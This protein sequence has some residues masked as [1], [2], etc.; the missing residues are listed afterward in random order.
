V[1]V[2]FSFE[3][4]DNGW[5]TF[6]DNTDVSNMLTRQGIHAYVR[7]FDPR[8]PPLSEYIEEDTRPYQNDDL[9]SF[10]LKKFI[11][12]T[13]LSNESPGRTGGDNGHKIILPPIIYG[14]APINTADPSEPK[15]P[16]SL[17]SSPGKQSASDES[18]SFPTDSEEDVIGYQHRLDR[19]AQAVHNHDPIMVIFVGE[20]Q[21]YQDRLA[22][23][24]FRLDYS[25]LAPATMK[26]FFEFNWKRL[27]DISI[28]YGGDS[29]PGSLTWTRNQITDDNMITSSYRFAQGLKV[30]YQSKDL[31]GVPMSDYEATYATDLSFGL[32]VAF[33]AA[34]R[35][36]DATLMQYMVNLTASWDGTAFS[37]AWPIFLTQ[38]SWRKSET[39][40]IYLE[41]S[42]EFA[43]TVN[44]HAPNPRIP[45]NSARFPDESEIFSDSDTSRT[46]KFA[47]DNG[48]PLHLSCASS[49]DETN[50]LTV[51]Y[52]TTLTDCEDKIH[53]YWSKFVSLLTSD[54][55]IGFPAVART[56]ITWSRHCF[57]GDHCIHIMLKEIGVSTPEE[58]GPP[59][60]L[61]FAPRAT[62]KLRAETVEVANR[63]LTMC[64]DKEPEIVQ[65]FHGKSWALIASIFG[66]EVN[67]RHLV[68]LR[69]KPSL[70]E[71]TAWNRDTFLHGLASDPYRVG[72]GKF[73][74]QFKPD[75]P[76]SATIAIEKGVHDDHGTAI[77]FEQAN[78]RCLVTRRI[79]K[80]SDEDT[81][82]E[83]MKD[84][85]QL[86]PRLAKPRVNPGHLFYPS[87]YSHMFEVYWDFLTDPIHH[88]DACHSDSMSQYASAASSMDFSD[89]IPQPDVEA[90]EKSQR[91]SSVGALSRRCPA[92]DANDYWSSPQDQAQEEC[93]TVSCG[94]APASD[95]HNVDTGAGDPT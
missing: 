27:C 44:P 59:C 62:L 17:K 68:Q 56:G 37:K 9:I 23:C 22:Q 90:S 85:A 25:G 87:E 28:A 18:D 34:P 10:R 89:F 75:K 13:D 11:Q 79:L 53:W 31:T 20:F 78:R 82:W 29:V 12:I 92:Q 72:T 7:T 51:T 33:P 86:Q 54:G 45:F 64:Y 42:L 66:G 32:S 21:G 39:G 91:V 19:I 48:W 58:D 26:E 76:Y 73:A 88:M 30:R 43:G 47:R 67:P 5:I 24:E 2:S 69:Q 4:K 35:L 50:S 16:G 65:E 77:L 3:V 60:F 83:V 15:L 6:P 71:V 81:F 74:A 1:K 63:M 93:V 41:A 84:W 49:F 8:I 14:A 40:E 70:E 57:I 94:F 95:V 36:T 52:E 38:Q 46:L 61:I 55:M 80:G